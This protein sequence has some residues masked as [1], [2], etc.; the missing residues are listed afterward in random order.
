MQYKNWLKIP[1]HKAYIELYVWNLYKIQY[2]TGSI[3]N[4]DYVAKVTAL[5]GQLGICHVPSLTNFNDKSS[6]HLP[7]ASF[8]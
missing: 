6:L 2:N 7:L 8:S 4:R 3:N 1:S 5:M